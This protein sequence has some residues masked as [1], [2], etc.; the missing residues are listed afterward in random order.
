M[1]RGVVYPELDNIHEGR[2]RS[3]VLGCV[4]KA[5]CVS[6]R[7]NEFLC[8]DVVLLSRQVIIYAGYLIIVSVVVDGSPCERP[9]DMVQPNLLCTIFF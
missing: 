2:N 1:P 5:T 8:G 9:A 3:C 7:V 4:T 6:H